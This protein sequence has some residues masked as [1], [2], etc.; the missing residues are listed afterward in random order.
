[1]LPEERALRSVMRRELRGWT[2]V[3]ATASGEAHDLILLAADDVVPPLQ[4]GRECS[5][6]VGSALVLRRVLQAGRTVEARRSVTIDPLLAC[7]GVEEIAAA[8]IASGFAIKNRLLARPD[9]ISTRDVI[10]HPHGRIVSAA[11][12]EHERHD[13]HCPEHSHPEEQVADEM[14]WGQ[15]LDG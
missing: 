7:G 12:A 13:R 14:P 5:V 3:G 6:A 15:H 4:T 1:M 9:I 2:G 11:R 10:A 8:R